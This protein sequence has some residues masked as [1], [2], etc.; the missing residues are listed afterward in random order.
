MLNAVLESLDFVVV[1]YVNVLAHQQYFTC[2]IDHIPQIIFLCLSNIL[3]TE[4]ISLVHFEN[5]PWISLSY[6]PGL[7]QC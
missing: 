6:L 2:L 7:L 4:K 5:A 3:E 1:L